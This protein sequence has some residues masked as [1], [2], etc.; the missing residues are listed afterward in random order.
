[1]DP[2]Q[3]C[4]CDSGK[5]WKWC[6]KNREREQP[7]HI[8]ERLAEMRAE[9]LKGYCSHP[10]AGASTCSDR[11]IRAHTVQRNVGLAGIAENGHVVSPRARIEDIF[12][13]E[14]KIVPNRIGVRSASTFMGF[15][16]RHDT[17]MFRPVE[18]GPVPLSSETCFLLS[19][20]ALAYECFTKRTALRTV[21][22]LRQMDNG[23]PFSMQCQIQQF[24][25]IYRQGLRRGMADLERWKISY[26]AEFQSG[27]FNTFRFY[28]VAFDTILPV[29]GCGAFHP[30]FDFSGQPLQIIS[31]GAAAHEHVVFNLTVLD[32][33]SVAVLGWME[34]DSG[35]AANFVLSFA[36]L[37]ESEKAEAA[38]R[39]GFEHLE[40]IY[41][42]P[43][44]WFG[45]P[46]ATRSAAM[47]R[48]RTGIGPGG[49]ERSP[50]CLRP[51]GHTYVS[52][53][54]VSET[55]QSCK[56]G[57]DHDGAILI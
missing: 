7:V 33:R 2:Y 11:I 1:M 53:I 46:D 45:L 38:V 9:S 15:C 26:D 24:L 35:P 56:N 14:G 27:R 3:L 57:D 40:N 4:W 19:F 54:G 21:D 41:L 8:A 16:S 5:K 36:R 25:S 32:G 18:A 52:N 44:W 34:G 48:M 12:K 50:K 28:G 10:E 51:D 6:H 20:R 39:L 29:V 37:S 30:E 47:V 13:N 43:T 55:I 17:E 23:S 42:N 22:I 49:N 31:R